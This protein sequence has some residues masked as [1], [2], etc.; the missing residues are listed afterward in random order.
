MSS[1]KNG[2]GDMGEKR[3]I[4]GFA[5]ELIVWRWTHASFISMSQELKYR[6]NVEEVPLLSLG[7]DLWRST[8][9]CCK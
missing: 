1:G 7:L 3:R 9:M 2:S 5:I 4:S 8:S 6:K